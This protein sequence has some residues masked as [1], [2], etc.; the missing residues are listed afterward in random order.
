MRII[1]REDFNSIGAVGWPHRV[2]LNID[3]TQDP[4]PYL[5]CVNDE[6]AWIG[7]R[8]TDL[9]P[10]YSS[11][12]VAPIDTATVKRD[13]YWRRA[14]E[15]WLD[16]SGLNRSMLIRRYASLT[17][18]LKEIGPQTWSTWDDVYWWEEGSD[19]MWEGLEIHSQ[20]D[21]RENNGGRQVVWAGTG[22]DRRARKAGDSH[23]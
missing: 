6:G 12:H 1:E 9:A 18:R 20:I 17:H 21:R 16:G 23:E 14:V 4:G 3:G 19:L 2:T 7:R 5:F 8:V 13:Q 11:F 10:G 22:R 15:I